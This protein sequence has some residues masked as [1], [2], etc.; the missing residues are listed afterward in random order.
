MSALSF[1]AGLTDLD[2]G[3]TVN[4]MGDKE[5]DIEAL[6]DAPF[7]DIYSKLEAAIAVP[8]RAATLVLGASGSSTELFPMICQIL[9]IVAHYDSASTRLG[10]G[11]AALSLG[12]F[13]HALDAKHLAA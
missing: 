12:M 5:R 11:A 7:A 10:G 1:K 9:S 3:K 4:L 13:S 6:L 8:G 2:T